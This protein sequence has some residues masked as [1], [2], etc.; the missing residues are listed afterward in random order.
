MTDHP[1]PTDIAAALPAP[2][3][4]TFASDNAAG[5]HPLVMDALAAANDGHAVAYGHDRWT[6]QLTHVMR[7]RLAAPVEV[8]PVWGGTGA[9]V[10][11]LA[12]LA[13]ASDAVVC[14][15][16]AHIHVDEAGAPERMAGTKL[17]AVP[18]ADGKL[19]P[20]DLRRHSAWHGDEHHPQPKILSVTQSTE[21]GTVYTPDELRELAD[22]AHALGMYVHLDGARIANAVAAIGG[23]L[24]ATTVEVGVDVLSFGGTKN[25]MM[26]GE[27]VVFCTPELASRAVFVRKQLAQLPS[28][29]RFISAQLLALFDDDLWLELATHANAMTGR[30]AHALAGAP[31]LELGT[32]PE[33]NSLFPR[34]PRAAIAPLQR[35]CPFYTWD[36][37]ADQVRW[38]TAWDTTHDDVDA[39]ATG[40]RAA[41]D[42]IGRATE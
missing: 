21:L 5:V 14:T 10:V 4:V 38:M 35:W 31:G 40:V 6:R 33:V 23:D 16:I 36:E 11:A 8:L 39:F 13:H 32:P 7:E 18:S 1:T 12:C 30:L 42:V 28:K 25:G 20:D 34:L 29:A 27:A 9:N 24:R 22:A 37:A 17:L 26:Y 19:R 41:L 3:Q 2:P 15:D